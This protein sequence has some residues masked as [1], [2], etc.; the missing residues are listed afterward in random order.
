MI[1]T[2]HS[3]RNFRTCLIACIRCGV[4]FRPMIDPTC[5]FPSKSLFK[6]FAEQILEGDTVSI[7]IWSVIETNVTG[8]CVCI[9]TTRPVFLRLLWTSVV[10]KTR[11]GWTHWIS[12]RFRS[13]S[14]TSASFRSSHLLSFRR[15]QDTPPHVYLGLQTKDWTRTIDEEQV[16]PLETL[17]FSR[18]SAIVRGEV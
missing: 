17:N 14:H 12:P 16:F 5:K 18:S 1:E 2:T 9:I 6:Q 13:G 10:K 8:V 7:A 11:R 15:L 3:L 4:L